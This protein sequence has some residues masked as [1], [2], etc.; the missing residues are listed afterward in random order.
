MSN[1]ALFTSCPEHHV[2]VPLT[3]M[4]DRFRWRCNM[5][6]HTFHTCACAR[7]PH[8]NI[9]SLL[10]VAVLDE[11]YMALRSGRHRRDLIEGP[12][13]DT[14]AGGA[15]KSFST[16]LVEERTNDDSGP[17]VLERAEGA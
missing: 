8:Y 5:N 4:P 16:W 13:W 14:P 3:R 6:M 11:A 17:L 7:R 2:G 9:A 10:P 12:L 1:N 15:S